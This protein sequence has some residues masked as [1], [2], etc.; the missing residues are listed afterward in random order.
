MPH[1]R[2]IALP[3]QTMSACLSISLIT[4]FLFILSAASLQRNAGAGQYTAESNPADS[5]D[6]PS[7]G[8]GER[9]NRAASHPAGITLVIMNDSEQ[10]PL[11]IKVGDQYIQFPGPSSWPR[12]ADGGRLVAGLA[13]A[14]QAHRRPVLPLRS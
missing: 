8:R 10:F 1:K 3:G 13:S 6:S 4:A 9:Q 2:S 12:D 5:V 14:A 7:A 11:A